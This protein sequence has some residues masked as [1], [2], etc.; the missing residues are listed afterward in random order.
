MAIAINTI[1]LLSIAV[2]LGTF[3]LGIFVGMFLERFRQ[4]AEKER[5]LQKFSK[6]AENENKGIKKTD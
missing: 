5:A 1:G 2:A 4:E 6:G 3:S